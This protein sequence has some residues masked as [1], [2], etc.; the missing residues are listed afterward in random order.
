M[1]NRLATGISV[2]RLTGVLAALCAAAVV[3]GCGNSDDADQPPAV[4]SDQREIL[5]TMD[6]LQ[7]ASRSGDAK[8]I[9]ND[10]FTESLATSIRRA[11]KRSCAAEVRE[12]LVSPDM[13]LSVGANIKITGR[14][15][16]AIVREQNGRTSR[17]SFVK[18]GSE[19]RI[20]RITK[21]RTS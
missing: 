2:P 20:E 5:R 14:H 9:C 3:G 17:V 10:I 8:R 15:A 19:W 6:A 13:R 21:A 11:A 16:T 1:A 4:P 7:A 18:Q 12:T